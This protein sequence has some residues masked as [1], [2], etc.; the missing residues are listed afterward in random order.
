MKK[1][2]LALCAVPALCWGQSYADLANQLA[3]ASASINAVPETCAAPAMQVAAASGIP[4]LLQLQPGAAKI[5]R[6]VDLSPAIHAVKTPDGGR[7]LACVVSV[8]WDNGQID[9]YY[10]FIVWS[11]RYGNINGFYGTLDNIR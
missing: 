6:V 9:R 4:V 8:Y 11:D 2:L 10:R 7:E 1:S 3:Q 5:K